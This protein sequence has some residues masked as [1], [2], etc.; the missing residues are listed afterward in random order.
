MKRYWVVFWLVSLIYGSSFLLNSV[1][2]RELAPIEVGV[3]RYIVAALGLHLYLRRQGKRLPLDQTTIRHLILVGVGNHA[4]PFV[5]IVW[6]QTQVQSGLAGV[7]MATTPLYS[8]VIAHFVFADERMSVR[9]A[10]GIALGFTGIL[11]LASRELS[12][13]PVEG[14][15]IA[16]LAI[17]VASALGA[18]TTVYSRRVMIGPVDP[19]VVSAG[20]MTVSAIFMVVAVLVSWLLGHGPGW[21]FITTMSRETW[22]IILMM[23]VVNTLIA[24][25][26]F[27]FLVR[28][29]GASRSTLVTYVYPPISLVLGVIFLQEVIDIHIVLGTMVILSGLAL[30]TLPVTLWRS[31]PRPV[32]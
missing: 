11:I 17:L 12:G 31:L 1:V 16:D 32:T 10:G 15:L 21:V 13:V 24:N 26:L 28:G 8:L 30:S 29:W 7:L 3:L 22:L 27:Y 6:A 19:M 14:H 18:A 2:L 9:K 20:T 4:I 25:T 23:G 5:L